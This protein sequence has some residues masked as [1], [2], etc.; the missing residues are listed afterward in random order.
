M[1]LRLFGIGL[2][3]QMAQPRPHPARP[4][5]SEPPV[6]FAPTKPPCPTPAAYFGEDVFYWC[7][8]CSLPFGMVLLLAFPAVGVAVPLLRSSLGQ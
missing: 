5:S 4:T 3:R 7:D 8:Q 6:A 2:E 1:E